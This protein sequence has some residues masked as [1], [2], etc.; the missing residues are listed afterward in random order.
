MQSQFHYKLKSPESENQ[1][2]F[3]NE[4]LGSYNYEAK[5]EIDYDSL[6][7]EDDTPV[8]NF[9]CEKQLRLLPESLKSSWNRK[10]P[11][12]V[13]ADVG[14]YEHPPDK[15]IVPDV[16][17]SLD[18]QYAEDIW[19]K[20]NRCYMIGI[21][22]KPPELVIEVVSNKTGEE[23]T[24]KLKRYEKIGIK[25]YVIFDPCHHILKSSIIQVY[26]LTGGLYKLYSEDVNECIWFNDLNVGMKVQK[27]I[28]EE[29][30][31]DWLRWCDDHG[32]IL[33]TGFERATAVEK[34]AKAVEQHA[35]A[36]EQ[37]ANKFENQ[38][39]FEQERAN[40]LAQELAKIKAKMAMNI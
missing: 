15:V 30:N 38:M 36:V 29:M 3:V 10:E 9:Y 11:Y 1:T 13:A 40:A 8:D 6:I 5:I 12:I 7:T 4:Y 27:G 37:R 22:G 20:R 25:Y 26:K 34:H 2:R 17:L 33:L 19:K 35:K 23:N 16:F 31:A 21:F 24:T 18:V 14:I 28:F 39:K 32:N